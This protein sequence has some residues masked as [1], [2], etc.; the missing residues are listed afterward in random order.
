MNI[1]YLLYFINF[2]FFQRNFF[3]TK[4]EYLYKEI[5][6]NL[7]NKVQTNFFIL[8]MTKY[9]HNCI[10]ESLQNKSI[11][12][13]YKL[14]EKSMIQKHK[15]DYLFVK[16]IFMINNIHKNAEKNL[17]KLEKNRKKNKR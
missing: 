3:H 10:R 15:M 1:L 2:S 17:K 14:L 16:H 12:I 9:E 11:S 4:P 8:Q 5:S 13:K 6:K 7:R